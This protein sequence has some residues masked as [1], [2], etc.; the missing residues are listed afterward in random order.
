MNE[1]TEIDTDKKLDLIVESIKEK[2]G[3]QITRID[4]TKIHNS[5]CDYFVICHANSTTQ[6]DAI[7]DSVQ[8]KLKKESGILAHHTEGLTNSRWVLIDYYDVLVHIFL[9]EMRS[10]YKLEELWADGEI[11]VVEEEK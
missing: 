3:K 10:F 6:V 1:N 5:I 7:A 11:E 4:L 9:D 8:T 2:K